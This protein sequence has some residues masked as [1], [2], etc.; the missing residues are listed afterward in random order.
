[1]SEIF[2]TRTIGYAPELIYRIAKD[3]ERLPEVLPD[4]DSVTILKDDG[5]GKV[6]SKWQG[7]ISVGP[8]TR[9]ISWIEEDIWD[10]KHL[11][12]RFDLIEGDM[13]EYS[14]LWTFEPVDGGCKVDLKVRFELGIPM[15]GP[16]VNR[17]V[18]QLMQRNCEDL[19]LA[20]E[21]LSAQQQGA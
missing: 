16:L 7:S 11:T 2:V 6:A 15:L 19:L 3:V 21:K 20:L 14:G 18:D 1:M 12:C 13:K 4:L 8:L 5:N 9:H 17:I 10:D